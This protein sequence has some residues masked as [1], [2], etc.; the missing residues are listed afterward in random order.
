MAEMQLMEQADKFASDVK[1]QRSIKTIL[2]GV[3]DNK[4]TMINTGFFR[5]FGTQN[6]Q[7]V[8]LVFKMNN[9]EK[10]RN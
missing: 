9:S 4:R 3:P 6:A 7:R 1:P 5:T 10:L 2:S 8:R